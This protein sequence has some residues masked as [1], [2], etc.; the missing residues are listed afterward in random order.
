MSEFLYGYNVVLAALEHQKRRLIKLHIKKP[1]H[2]Q[3]KE[4]QALA[5]RRQIPMVEARNSQLDKWSD[6]RPHQVCFIDLG[7]CFASFSLPNHSITWNEC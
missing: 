3:I 7:T 4:L 1:P 5:E 2:A 6:G